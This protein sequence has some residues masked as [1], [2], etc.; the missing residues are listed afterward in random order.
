MLTA[1]TIENDTSHLNGS[2][3]RVD[4]E[5]PEHGGGSIR[6]P[7]N[8]TLTPA[9][10]AA[11]CALIAL[12]VRRLGPWVEEDASRRTAPV[13]WHPDHC[14]T[15]VNRCDCDGPYACGHYLCR[16]P[17]G[18]DDVEECPGVA[19]MRRRYADE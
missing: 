12:G 15:C 1:V 2:T 3:M 19:V 13:E 11:D 14:R 16:H 5:D 10:T 6:L 17:A 7:W 9:A 8:Y 18:P 4:I